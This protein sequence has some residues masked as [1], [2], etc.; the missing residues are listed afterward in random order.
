MNY[1]H[2]TCNIFLVIFFNLIRYMALYSEKQILILCAK[3]FNI[4]IF[5][6]IHSYE[7]RLWK[8]LGNHFIAIGYKNLSFSL[9]TYTFKLLMKYVLMFLI[10]GFYRIR[11]PLITLTSNSSDCYIYLHA[12]IHLW[13]LLYTAFST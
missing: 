9:D 8:N 1:F 13:I 11:S 3:Q 10:T 7:T 6:H 2:F 12:R 5:K 4:I